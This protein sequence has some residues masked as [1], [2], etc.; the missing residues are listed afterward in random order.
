MHVSRQLNDP[1]C[2][3]DSTTNEGDALLHKLKTGEE[4]V[5]VSTSLLGVALNILDIDCV[6]H[7]GN[8]WDALGDIQE[9]RRVGRAPGAVGTAIMLF[10]ENNPTRVHPIVQPDLLVLHY[11]AMLLQ[12]GSIVGNCCYPCSSMALK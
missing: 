8:L 7:Y 3:S 4:T 12:T 11:S 6:I 2:S 10:P 5:L 9:S 1:G